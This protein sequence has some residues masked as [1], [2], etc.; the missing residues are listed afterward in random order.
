MS[1]A[2]DVM[3][4]TTLPAFY[5]GGSERAELG[6]GAQADVDG[7]TYKTVQQWNQSD[8]AFLRERA[9]RLGA[10]VWIE[11]DTLHVAARERRSS[12]SGRVTLIQGNDLLALEVRADLAHQ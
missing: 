11:D 6:I 10:D 3:Y 9:Q 1:E 4:D 8:L 2:R 12:G 7:P 5:V